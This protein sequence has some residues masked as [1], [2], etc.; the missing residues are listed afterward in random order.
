MKIIETDRLI[1]RTW[2]SED[3]E[4]YFQINQDPNVIEF[5]LGTLTKEQVQE[6]ITN[7]NLTFK[8]MGFC[9]FATELKETNKLIG[10]IGLSAPKFVAHFMPAVEIGWRLGSKYW[11]KG[12]AT[13]GAKAVIKFGF[14]NLNL[15]EIVSFTVAGNKRSIAVM[16]KLG[17]IRDLEGDFNHPLLSLDHK[18]SKHVLYRLKR[19]QNEK[20]S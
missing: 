13:E 10:F 1:L 6:F 11:G 14:N 18:L 2:K 5:L 19:K 16:E 17:M 15:D 7:S 8:E 4:S 20:T 9:L 12:Y 3:A